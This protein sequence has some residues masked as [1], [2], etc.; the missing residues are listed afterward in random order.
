MESPYGPQGAK[1]TA[2]AASAIARAKVW[3]GFR[4]RE[5]IL[6]ARSITEEQM[7]ARLATDSA[8]LSNEGPGWT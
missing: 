2:P 8:R 3:A 4:R 6:A 5:A 1:G 7:P